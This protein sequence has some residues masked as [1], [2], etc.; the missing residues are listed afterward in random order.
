M[1]SFQK[2]VEQ[3]GKTHAFRGAEPWLPQNDVWLPE[4][5]DFDIEYRKTR[6]GRCIGELPADYRTYGDKLQCNMGLLKI[7][8]REDYDQQRLLGLDESFLAT[9]AADWVSVMVD[10]VLNWAGQSIEN[11]REDHVD[12]AE[13]NRFLVVVWDFYEKFT[14]AYNKVIDAVHDGVGKKTDPRPLVTFSP[15]RIWG[16]QT[17]NADKMSEL[18]ETRVGVVSL[19]SVFAKFP[20]L[21][22]PLA[23]EVFG[24]DISHSLGR[25]TSAHL[26]PAII[27]EFKEIVAANVS[28]KWVPTWLTWTE[29]VAADLA[30]LL[31]MG[32]Y[33]AISFAALMSV[34]ACSD[35]FAPLWRP[36]RVGTMLLARGGQPYD[37]HPPDLLRLY[38]MRG[39]A[40]AL[41]GLQGFDELSCSVDTL[42]SVVDEAHAPSDMIDVYDFDSQ[43]VLMRYAG[44][45]LISDAQKIGQHIITEPLKSLG[46]R[47]ITD[48]HSWSNADETKAKQVAK[49]ARGQ[50]QV[51][52]LPD[53][54]DA[55][56]LLA[57]A[58]MALYANPGAFNDINSFLNA[59]L[60]ER[61]A[62][63]NRFASLKDL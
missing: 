13:F 11:P 35:P 52:Q 56:H 41:L 28:P 58:T 6:V 38:A 57:G 46:K 47:R 33:F 60:S 25:T 48:F 43:S 55:S 53:D 39:A 7:R 10:A 51:L 31:C 16:P 49:V 4:W 44:D 36:G 3:F 9:Q 24:H 18:I 32:P 21:W 40:E 22:A 17:I 1:T 54:V 19:P 20:L 59:A 50:S 37:E 42:K 26:M 8:L 15:T 45:D 12:T 5:Q 61:A 2:L 63:D 34:S 27:K 62:T 14:T 30:G 23:H 29:E